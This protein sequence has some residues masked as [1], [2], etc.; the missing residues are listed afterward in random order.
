MKR[1]L[2]ILVVAAAFTVPAQAHAFGGFFFSP[3]PLSPVMPGYCP[4]GYWA[5][6]YQPAVCYLPQWRTEPVEVM[7]PKL[8]WKQEPVKTKVVNYVARTVNEK[9]VAYSV[10]YEPKVV[11]GCIAYDVFTEPRT[12]AAPTVK[13]E[14]EIKEVDSL[15]WAP[16]WRNEKVVTYRYVCDWVPVTTMKPTYAFIP[17]PAYLESPTCKFGW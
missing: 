6:T 5:C 13:Y 12:L 10:R 17:S 8:H 2:S 11:N 1:W 3:S 15:R 4:V 16:E 7:V 14:P 9:K